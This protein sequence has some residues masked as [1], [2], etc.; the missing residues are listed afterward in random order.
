MESSLQVWGDNVDCLDGRIQLEDGIEE[1]TD[2]CR[3]FSCALES[4]IGAWINY[5]E[6]ITHHSWKEISR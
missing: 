5:L 4:V 3:I 1:P 2:N 6:G